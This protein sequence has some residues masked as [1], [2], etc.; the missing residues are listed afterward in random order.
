MVPQPLG[1]CVKRYVCESCKGAQSLHSSVGMHDVP[2][3]CLTTESV[4]MGTVATR[5]QVLAH[6]TISA[7]EPAGWTPVLDQSRKSDM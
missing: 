1:L 5:V 4:M 6:M 2:H 7:K 3:G